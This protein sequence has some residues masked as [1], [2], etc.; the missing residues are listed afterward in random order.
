MRYTDDGGLLCE[1]RVSKPIVSE[2]LVLI[3]NGRL[4]GSAEQVISL[5]CA[6]LQAEG[7]IDAG[8]LEAVLERERRF[9]T[10]LPTLPYPTAIPH[11]DARH[12]RDTGVA[13]AILGHAVPFRAMD[14]PDKYLPVR[15]V[16]LLAVAHSSEQVSTLHWVCEMLNRQQVVAQLVEADS[17]S[18]AM[19]VLRP[20]LEYQ[21]QGVDHHVR[22][23]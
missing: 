20:L 6:R 11:A 18:T 1:E 19:A 13:V 21:K 9:P 23:R 16:L 4:D 8:Y 7:Y 2:R 12:V 14:A 5:L 10:A 22:D 15:A 3:E 17:P